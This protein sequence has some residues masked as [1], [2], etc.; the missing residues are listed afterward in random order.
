VKRELFEQA[1]RLVCEGL[2]VQ[3]M[4]VSEKEY[5]LKKESYD[6]EAQINTVSDTLAAGAFSGVGSG[7][8]YGMWFK[9]NHGGTAST[10]KPDRNPSCYHACSR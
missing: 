6:A 8:C 9:A 7:T 10:G 3:R 5:L 2:L 1:E 4:E